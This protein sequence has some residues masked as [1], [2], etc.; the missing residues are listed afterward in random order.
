MLIL[1]DL[2]L[3]IS[4][5]DMDRDGISSQVSKIPPITGT[6]LDYRD[7]FTSSRLYTNDIISQVVLL[8]GV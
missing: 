1:Y 2:F 4:W 8:Y 3:V 7:E 5:R 6:E